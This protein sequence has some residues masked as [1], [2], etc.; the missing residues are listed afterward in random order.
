VDDDLLPEEP[1][2]S[3]N[4]Q[5]FLAAA[6]PRYAF[7]KEQR[8]KLQ[9]Q[10]DVYTADIERL[11]TLHERTRDE[12]AS[13]L[14]AEVGDTEL[15]AL[16]RR[17]RYPGLLSIKSGFEAELRESEAERAELA[18]NPDVEH[19]EF[20]DGQA[21]DEMA[22]LQE[23]VDSYR[24]RIGGWQSSKWF[25]E[26]DD[27]GFFEHDYEPDLFDQFWDWRA[28]SWLM[29][30]LEEDL[31]LDFATPAAVRDAWVG[32]DQESSPVLEAFDDLGA[33]LQHL[34]DLKTRHDGLVAA[35][36]LIF[37][38]MV[39]AL[40]AAVLDHLDSCPPDLKTT[41]AREDP[42][43][44]TFFKK[45]TGLG[46]QVQY[47]KQLQVVRIQ[48]PMQ[49]LTAEMDKLTRKAQK[50][51]RKFKYY[52]A[53][54]IEGMRVLKEEKWAKRHAKL[55]KVRGRVAGFKQYE[56]GDFGDDYLWWDVMTRGAPGDDIYE[57][58]TFRRQRP[59]W[60]YRRH[61]D[62]WHHHHH[63]EPSQTAMDTAADELADRMQP[64]G[65]DW[66]SDAS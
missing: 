53:R 18:A 11:E 66:D 36:P 3:Y 8:Q 17:L 55:A 59:R 1:A 24:L 45:E 12:L 13:Y 54:T 6:R 61:E 38:R 23:A 44:V 5:D 52:D 22:A 64:A 49:S 63:Q 60:D 46:K 20:H 14:L 51:E 58:R 41:L 16:Q 4:S 62:R 39:V 35:P 37:Q 27:R 34:H 29:D 56:Q 9:H 40:S 30:D 65:S 15:N 10:H 33:R 28:V 31:D 32:L 25:K 7:L 50:A 2:M 43:L 48:A 42:Y 47:L 21:R 19:N 26:L 57:V